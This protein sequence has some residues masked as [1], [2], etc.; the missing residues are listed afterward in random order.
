MVDPWLIPASYQLDAVTAGAVIKTN[1]CVASVSQS[2]DPHQIVWTLADK[3]GKQS[4]TAR[5]VVNAAGAQE[6]VAMSPL[7]HIRSCP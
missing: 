3:T 4:V 6:I 7:V 5:V 1:F 2:S